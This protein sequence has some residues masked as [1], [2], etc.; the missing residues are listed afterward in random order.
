VVG[1]GTTGNTLKF[2]VSDSGDP[3]LDST[4]YISQLGGE[5]PPPPIPEPASIALLGTA[6]VLLYVNRKRLTARAR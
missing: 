2:I 3:I 5:P 1:A 6:A 4:A